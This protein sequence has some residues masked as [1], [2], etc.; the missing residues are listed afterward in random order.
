MKE[1]EKRN[2]NLGIQILRFLLCLWVLIIHCS[3]IENRH[4]KYFGKGFHVPTFIL[5]SFYFFYNNI[6]RRNIPKII[7]RFQRLL[8][9]YILWPIIILLVNNFLISFFSVGQFRILS[10]YS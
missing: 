7:L 5:L 2:I 1:K 4:K 10:I 3:Y 8:I 9:P 6:N